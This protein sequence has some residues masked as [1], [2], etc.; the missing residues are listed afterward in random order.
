LLSDDVET[1]LADWWQELLGMD[2]V[3]LDDDFFELGGHSLLVVRLFSKINKTYGINIGLS[4]F[5]EAGTIRTLARLIRDGCAKT[6]GQPLSSRAVVPIR[7]SGTRPPLY[8]TSGLDGHVLGFH[9]MALY[10]GEDQPVF[11]LV[12]RIPDGA[13]PYHATVEEMAAYYVKAIR[14]HQPEGPYRVAGHSFGG[15]VAF[16]VAQQIMALGGVVDFLG[17]FDT[18]ERQYVK[19]VKRSLR[20]RDRVSSVAFAFR[21]AIAERDPFGPV[22]RR[23]N[24][25]TSKAISSISPNLG[26]PQWQAKTSIK[27][28]NIY[29]CE[30][31][32]PSVYPGRLTLFRSTT[33]QVQDGNDEFL[34]WGR[35]A[36]GGVEVHDVPS[37]HFN[38]IDEPAVGILSEILQECLDRDGV[39]ER[40]AFEPPARLFSPRPPLATRPVQQ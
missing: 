13:E 8:V 16:E 30:I 18:I 14:K 23:L 27:D 38:M 3:G 22:R 11:G 40:A 34:G 9:R 39:V 31:N 7:A 24:R 29:S 25:M 12:P 17:L 6:T 35:L 10:L 37:T 26:S 2:Q 32:R 19:E 15:I 21:L 36:A 4:T 5:F 33:R 28:M 1:V 20:F